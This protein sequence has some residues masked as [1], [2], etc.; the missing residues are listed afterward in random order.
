[1]T[2][3]SRRWRRPAAGAMAILLTYAL[4]P[5]GAGDT[6]GAAKPASTGCEVTGPKSGSTVTGPVTI[7]GTYTDAYQ[8]KVA[9]DAGTVHD[10][11]TV[12]PDGDD[13]GTWSYTLDP[14]SPRLSGEVEVTVRCSSIEDRY[15]RWGT[16]RTIDVDIP[17]QEPPTVAVTSPAEGSTTSGTVPVE[18]EAADARGLESVQVRVDW[19]TWKTATPSATDTYVYEWDAPS[20]DKTHAIE[21]RAT[22]VDGNTTTTAT[23]Y[24]HTGSGTDEPPATPQSDRA[25]WV[26]E[27]AT[28]QLLE[29]PGARDVLGEFMDDESLARQQRSTIYLYAD[30]YDGDYALLDRPEQYRSLIA[31]AHERGYEV[32]ALLGSGSYMAPMWAY[33]RHHDKALQLVETV[34]NY[35][36][37]SDPAERFDGINVDIEPHGL[38][39]WRSKRKSVQPQYLDMLAKM[40]DRK[41]ASGQNLDI[42][43]AIP[44]WLDDNRECQKIIWNHK[45]QN[46][47]RHII[48]T[49]DYVTLMDYR[50]VADGPAG[51]I[52][53]AQSEIDYA[54]AV[55]KEVMIGVETGQ[56]SASGDP[57]TISFQEEGRTVMETEL[58]KVYAAF[59]S[60]ESFLGVAVH[61][62]DSDRALPSE[63]SPDGTRWQHSI[64]DTASPST[65]DAVTAEV[66]DW[67]RIDLHWARSSD[68]TIV[69]HYE[70]H[71]STVA[72]FTPGPDT[73]ANTTGFNFV[74]D[75]GLEPGTTYYWKVVA[76]DAT[77][78]R[79]PAS[80]Q[81]SRTTPAGDGSAPLRIGSIDFSDE[82]SSSTAAITVV[83]AVTGE[84][85]EGAQVFGHWEGAAGRKFDATT[86]PD[87]TATVST[88]SLT[89]PYT[90]TVVPEKIL[91]AGH[92]WASS[93]DTDDS[94][95]W[96]G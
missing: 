82:A 76:V 2:H 58:A 38:P 34:L 35:N 73:L 59:E 6:A 84:P 3:S 36:L 94:A 61:H 40:M 95:T 22:D 18:V 21:A 64:P 15:W 57:E 4:V 69:E 24:V 79:S 66:H 85:V 88:E 62:Y 46:C 7:T 86:G 67:Q 25:M 30:R 70:V 9:F 78:N 71:R 33:S 92:Y 52:P 60:S 91:A 13:T 23:T 48:D 17:A 1:M 77:G 32:H 10:A 39:D 72:G 80:A 68:D 56:I 44:R 29:N 51:I 65:P 45:K 14:S 28:Y 20:E 49:T 11:H 54:D 19:G 31:W 83:D 50:D 42:G 90:V 43:P 75:R 27:P 53:H 87:G 8:V 81:V 47:A 37:S 93:L 12:D 16:P 5:W 96:N 26:W 55:G 74:K 63:W 89:A 41:A